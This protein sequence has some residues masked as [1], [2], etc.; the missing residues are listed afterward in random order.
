M[1]Y[2]IQVHVIQS[3]QQLEHVSLDLLLVQLLGSVLDVLV[4]VLG[5]EL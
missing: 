1:E 5:H 2:P 3:I 4:H